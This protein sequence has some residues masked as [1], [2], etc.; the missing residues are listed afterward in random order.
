MGILAS[1]SEDKSLHSPRQFLNAS[2]TATP[3]GG[4]RFEDTTT[5]ANLHLKSDAHVPPSLSPASE[6]RFSLQEGGKPER[7]ISSKLNMGGK[8][9]IG[10]SN[11]DTRV[12]MN[13]REITKVELRVLK[14]ED[15]WVMETD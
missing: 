8:L 15:C 2:R 7:I 3:I 12:Y 1:D 13:G 9:Q 4:R 6:I 14:V 5:I 10:A 11:G